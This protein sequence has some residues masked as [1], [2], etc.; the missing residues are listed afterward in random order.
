[1]HRHV[2]AVDVERGGHAGLLRWSGPDNAKP[3][4]DAV[5]A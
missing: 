3:L 5:K 1:L 2:L 4:A